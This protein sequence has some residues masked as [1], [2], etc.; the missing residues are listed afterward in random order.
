MSTMTKGE[1]AELRQIVKQQFKVLVAEVLVRQREFEAEVDSDLA[2]RF[3]DRDIARR[4]VEEKLAEITLEANAKMREAFDVEG[5]DIT[6]VPFLEHQIPHIRWGDDGRFERRRAAYTE[7]SARIQAALLQ[8][9]R[10]EADV[11]R[12]LA[13]DAIE[14]EAAQ[15]FLRSIPTVA[16]L[17]PAQR[18]AAL[19]A[20]FDEDETSR[21]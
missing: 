12:T 19:E 7:I 8:L 17:V 20:A 16:E 2:L 3:A 6:G 11:L 1:R 5:F 9:Q 4:K 21:P 18:L 14:S 10:Q 15:Q 13:I